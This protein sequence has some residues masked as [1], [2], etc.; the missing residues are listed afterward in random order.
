[1]SQFTL[2]LKSGKQIKLLADTQEA[3]MKTYKAFNETAEIVKCHLT[4][5]K[6]EV[7]FGQG[8]NNSR[9]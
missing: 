4:D 5:W 3:A 6:W 8:N 7:N 2:T 1:M 9:S